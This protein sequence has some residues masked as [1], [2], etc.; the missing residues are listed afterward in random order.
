[1]G[2]I[3]WQIEF[4]GAALVT[5]DLFMEPAVK[6]GG[7]VRYWEQ[8]LDGLGQRLDDM[9]VAELTAWEMLA[10]AHK[11]VTS[12]NIHSR[13]QWVRQQLQWLCSEIRTRRRRR[14]IQMAKGFHQ[15]GVDPNAQSE[16]V[17]NLFALAFPL[18]CRR[19]IPTTFF[20]D[21]HPAWH[22]P[23]LLNYVVPARGINEI[24]IIRLTDALRSSEVSN[25]LDA[26][27]DAIVDVATRQLA[28]SDVE[29]DP[30]VTRHTRQFLDAAIR[31]GRNGAGSW[32]KTRYPYVTGN[33]VDG[34]VILDIIVSVRPYEKLEQG[35]SLNTRTNVDMDDDFKSAVQDEAALAAFGFFGKGVREFE[36][37]IYLDDFP[38]GVAYPKNGTWNRDFQLKDG[39]GWLASALALGHGAMGAISGTPLEELGCCP[40]VATGVSDRGSTASAVGG[41]NHV[42]EKSQ[43]AGLWGADLYVPLKDVAE[44]QE[45][46]RSAVAAGASRSYGVK[47]VKD[48]GNALTSWNPPEPQAWARPSAWWQLSVSGLSVLGVAALGS[49][50]RL[51]VPDSGRFLLA[52]VGYVVLIT[53][54]MI[55]VTRWIELRDARKFKRRRF[56]DAASLIYVAMSFT[57]AVAVSLTLYEPIR[58]GV[59]DAL[60]LEILIGQL[61]ATLLMV[62]ARRV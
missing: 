22:S 26:V 35:A 62:L 50:I 41:V 11:Q 8:R 44:A 40:I 38:G 33:N 30:V 9:R 15:A 48:F 57:T 7:V 56:E 29:L 61:A 20:D 28:A 52:V 23:K 31:E 25:R 45:G 10:D 12:S 51:D 34:T 21:E 18:L 4:G 37:A 13:G 47:G 42:R 49:G 58:F 17:S 24:E 43:A 6:H 19:W 27:F 36:T 2:G 60:N 1:M 14:A 16:A 5:R 53:S 55:V 54:A 39:S 46:Q 3:N 32:C 59:R